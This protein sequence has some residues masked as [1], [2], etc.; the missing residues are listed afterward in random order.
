MDFLFFEVK[1][2]VWSRLVH[3]VMWDIL[4]DGRAGQFVP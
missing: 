4:N 3:E 1:G 2:T